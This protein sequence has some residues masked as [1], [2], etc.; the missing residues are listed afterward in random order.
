MFC[1][2]KLL[3]NRGW[4]Q[5]VRI[6]WGSLGSGKRWGDIEM[7]IYSGFIGML[8]DYAGSG[9]IM[10]ASGTWDVVTVGL[11]CG[12]MYDW[13]LGS[14]KGLKGLQDQASS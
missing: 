6:A 11:S 14:E 4:G 13:D 12:A 9:G 3:Q 8:H 5:H 2:V 10:E 7:C 1:R